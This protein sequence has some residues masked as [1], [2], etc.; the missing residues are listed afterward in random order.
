[1]YIDERAGSKDLISP[2]TD[3]GLPVKGDFLEFGDIAFVGRG[4]KGASVSIGIEHKKLNDLV[5][6]LNTDRLAGHQ[7]PGLVINYDR[8][9]LIVEG[10]WNHDQ[11]GRTTMWKGRGARRPVKGAP[12][13]V[14]LEKRLLTLETRGGVR[15][16]ICPTR[17]DTLR[18]LVAMYRFWT[19]KALDEHK[20]HLAIHN[21]DI[22]PKLR[23]D[24]SDF[25]A[26]LARWP[27][28]GYKLSAAF[29]DYYETFAAFA[30]AITG[31]DVNGM[32]DILTVDDKGKA[33]RLG[34]ARA[35]KIITAMEKTR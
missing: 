6:S 7:L 30:E 29:E 28:I 32:A 16:R 10:D 19:D 9:W 22:D 27:G 5:Q 8:A 17:R 23:E 35:L 33:R 14:E 25:R 3:L 1:M 2:L 21:P 11:Q 15:V 4:E 13:A 20:S 31:A 34:E 24:V 18:F 12:L 26:I